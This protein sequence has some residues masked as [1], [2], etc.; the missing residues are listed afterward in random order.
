MVFGNLA[1][2]YQWTER[3]REDIDENGKSAGARRQDARLLALFDGIVVTSGPFQGMRYP[4]AH[5]V[6]SALFPKLLGSYER[7][8]A[9]VLE[10]ILSRPYDTIYDIG[11]AE[12]YY[13][14][15]LK[16]RLPEARVV[17]FDL[18]AEG[19]SLCRQM[20]ALN[21]VEVEVREACTTAELIALAGTQR[22]L[23]MSD[24]EGCEGDLFTAE[25]CQALSRHDLLI[26]VHD[27]LRFGLTPALRER[28]S[29]SHR[30]TEIRSVDDVEKLY[31]YHYPLL[32]G[33]SDRDRHRALS[34][35]R[36]PMRWIFA[37]G[38]QAPVTNSVS[39][40]V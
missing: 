35:Y 14:V 26:E 21:E 19:R 2:F 37:E 12:G 1:G 6:G 34:E 3:V 27:H 29:S 8:L 4:S 31:T 22:A 24:C 38:T 15:G 25:V 7:E 39:A 40:T 13:A 20:A 5:S 23:V 16:L 17:A 36:C 10:T 11:C 9:P 32:E 30:I 18:D 33:L 28:L